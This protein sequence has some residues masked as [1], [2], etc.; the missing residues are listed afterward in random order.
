VAELANPFVPVSWGELLDKISILEIKRERIERAE[1][2]ANVVREHAA[3]SQVGEAALRQP[4]VAALFA[5]LKAVN[6]AL[7]EIE[8]AIREE[9]AKG[10][11]GAAFV[12]LARSVYHR[13]DERAAIKREIN[14]R[15][16]SELIEEKSYADPRGSA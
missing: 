4:E 3:L 15:L 13:N 12:S 1:A 9:E 10:E 2:V 16:K 7:W 11:F 5:R 6:E 8:D 14:L